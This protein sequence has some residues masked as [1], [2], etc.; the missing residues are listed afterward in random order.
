MVADVRF[1]ARLC[2]YCLDDD[3]V[4]FCDV[5]YIGVN[6]DDGECEEDD[7]GVDVDDGDGEDVVDDGAGEDVEDRGVSRISAR[8]VLKVR[9]HTKSGGGGGGGGSPLQVR[10][11][12]SGGQSTSGPI[13]EKW[14]GS[15]LQVPYTKSGGGAVHFRSDIRKVGGGGGGRQF[16]SGPIR[17]V[18]GG[19]SPLQDR[20]L[21]LA[22]R[23]Y[24]IVNYKRLQF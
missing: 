15:P 21:C 2:S 23:K 7:A 8:G 9:P 12:K 10:Y 16:A 11:T 6:E 19:A 14:G 13:Y 18:G 5:G 3:G 4:G 17:K 20:Y 22:L 24:F 1:S